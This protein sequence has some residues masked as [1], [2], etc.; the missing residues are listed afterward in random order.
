MA[1]VGRYLAISPAV[2]YCVAASVQSTKA[3][4]QND[5]EVTRYERTSDSGNMTYRDFCSTCGT[6][7]FSGSLAFPQIMS[8]KVMT[9][10]DPDV[11]HRDQH[12][13]VESAVSWVCM[14]DHL[15]RNDRQQSSEEFSKDQ[16]QA[17]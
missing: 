6:Q 1:A 16:D 5:G 4:K 7:L 9:F 10:D 11:V 17:E 2:F 12:V 8:V 14:N 13:W 15:P 3:I